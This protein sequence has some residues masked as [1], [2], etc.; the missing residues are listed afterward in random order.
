MTQAKLPCQTS[1]MAEWRAFTTRALGE[2]EVS[3]PPAQ[4]VAVFEA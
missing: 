4:D 3:S 2:H 1:R